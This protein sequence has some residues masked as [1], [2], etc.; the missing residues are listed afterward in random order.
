MFCCSLDLIRLTSLNETVY[1]VWNTIVYQNSTLSTVGSSVGNYYTGQS[2][3]Q[4]FDQSTGTKYVSFGACNSTYGASV[5]QCGQNTGL[6]LTLQQG[7]SLLVAFRFWT[8]NS[9][10]LRDPMN[11][12]IEGSNQPT[13]ALLL[14][15]SWN[16][17]YS[18]SSGLDTDPGRLSFGQMQWLSNNTVWYSSYRLLIQTK[19]G[20]GNFVQYSEFELFGYQ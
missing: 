19:R 6:Y 8:A 7:S 20:G 11:I 16:L 17:I 2:P 12:T 18:G 5:I 3:A 10:P 13:S 1:A 15:S 14:G 4:V 9:Y